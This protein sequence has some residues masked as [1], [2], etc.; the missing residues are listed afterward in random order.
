MQT[1]NPPKNLYQKEKAQWNTIWIL[2][3]KVKVS[4]KSII[5][6]NLYVI[7]NNIVMSLE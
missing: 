1:E 7:P 3:P 2:L 5:P 6:Q 4:T